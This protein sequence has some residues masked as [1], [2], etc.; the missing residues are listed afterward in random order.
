M[1]ALD[2]WPSDEILTVNQQWAQ[3]RTV[4]DKLL[5]EC[6]WTQLPD[7]N[8]TADDRLDWAAYRQSLRDLPQAFEQPGDVILPRKP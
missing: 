7:A 4:R 5:Q 2:Y 6:D 3:I 8:L 1:R